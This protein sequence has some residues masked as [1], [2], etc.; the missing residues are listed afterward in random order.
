MDGTQLQTFYDSEGNEVKG[1]TAEKFE[2]LSAKIAEAEKELSGLRNKDLNFEK[3]RTKTEAEK[4]EIIEGMSQKERLLYEKI[5]SL[6]TERETEKVARMSEA[7][8]AVLSQLAGS[9]EALR[10]AIE[11]QEKEFI[12]AAL[13]PKDYEERLRKAF[14]LVKGYKP[15]VN[16]LNSPIGAVYREPDTSKKRY[17][18]TDEGRKKFAAMFPDSPTVQQWKKDGK[19]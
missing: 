13:T 11:A 9:D 10:Q 12:G 15:K 14:T 3:F 7:K 8:D 2:E 5:E 6:E 19:L 18:D 4:K 1:I 17:T 16:P